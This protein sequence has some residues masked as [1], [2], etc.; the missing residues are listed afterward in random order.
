[1]MGRIFKCSHINGRRLTVH[2]KNKDPQGSGHNTKP[3]GVQ[4]TFVQ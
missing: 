1:M 3:A 4:K 2:D